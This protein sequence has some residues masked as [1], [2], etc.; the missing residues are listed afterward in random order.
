MDFV[1]GDAIYQVSVDESTEKLRRHLRKAPGTKRVLVR[2][3]ESSHFAHAFNE[4][5]LGTIELQDLLEHF[6]GWMLERD[7]KSS[8]ARHLQKVL[9]IALEEFRRE[10]RAESA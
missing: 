1:G 7:M 6:I 8:H 5:V 3:N 4:D 2:P 9:Q 10:N